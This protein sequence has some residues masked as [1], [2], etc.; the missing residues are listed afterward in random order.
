VLLFYE[1]RGAVFGISAS[2]KKKRESF[3]SERR[4][5]GTFF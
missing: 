5:I 4:D 2:V 3:V 1:G